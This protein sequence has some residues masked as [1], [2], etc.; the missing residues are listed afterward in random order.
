MKLDSLK[1]LLDHHGPLTTVCLDVSRDDEAGDKEVR[2]RWQGVRRTLESLG[3]PT[4]SMDVLEEVVLTKTGV[5][6]PH[7]RFVVAS[8]PDVLYDRLLAA[9]PVRAEAFHDGAPALMPAVHAECEWV[10]FLLVAVDRA[11]ADL[12]WPGLGSR[13]NNGESQE[14]VDG[15]H[16]VL[17]KVRRGGLSNRR[18]QTR[19]EDSWERNAAAVAAELDKVVMESKPELVLLTGDVRAV[20]LLRDA[21]GRPTAELIVEVA[22]GSRAEGVNEHAF[23]LQVR[24]TLEEYR[25]R[26]RERVANRLRQELGR[27]EAAVTELSDVVEVLRRGQVDELVIMEDAAG[28]PAPLADRQI[29]VGSEPLELGLTRSDVEALGVGD[30]AHQL[31]ADIAVLRAVIAQDAGVTFLLEGNADLV[32]GIGAL[33]R[34]SDAATPS[35]TA[36]AYSAGVG[37]HR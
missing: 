20:A 26:R 33:L 24:A 27:G 2:N 31:R 37:R 25:A 5:P 28:V 29:W 1:P 18:M 7:G 12:T 34:W 17:H 11:G 13:L 21:V 10:D 15:G 30:Q 4:E 22:G 35:E 9:P 3:T 14:H 32:D 19:V 6:G 16:D 36:P 23:R 8:G